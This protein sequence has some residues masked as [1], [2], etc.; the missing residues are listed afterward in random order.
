MRMPGIG[1][2]TN[3]GPFLFLLP[4]IRLQHI[5]QPDFQPLPLSPIRI[6]AGDEGVRP[7]MRIEFHQHIDILV[8]EVDRK[9]L[10]GARPARR[11]NSAQR[12]AL[13]RRRRFADLRPRSRRPLGIGDG[14]ARHQSTHAFGPAGPEAGVVPQNL[15]LGMTRR[16]RPHLRSG[17]VPSKF[18]ASRG[19][20]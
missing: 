8:A 9:L 1:N 7:D 3:P 16:F 20:G 18:F 13:R 6:D 14:Q 11:R 15:V 2:E 17:S 19:N 5:L 12:L 10:P 4:I